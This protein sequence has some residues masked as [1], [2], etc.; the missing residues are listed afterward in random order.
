MQDQAI[1]IRWFPPSWLLIETNNQTIYIDPAW[2][3]KN[4][5]SY[6]NK[7][8]F[9]HY[10]DPMDGLPEPDLPKADIILITHHHQDHVKTA[11]INRLATKE[12]RIYAP[13][14]CSELIART[15]IRVNPGD[16]FEDG[17]AKF[18]AIFS[19][20]TPEGHSTHKV[21]HKG[22]CVGYLLTV[23]EKTLYHAGDTDLIPEMD[24]LG[25][26][27]MAFLPVGGTFTMDHEEALMASRLIKP[28]WFTPIH[29]RKADD[30][31]FQ[32]LVANETATRVHIPKIGEPIFL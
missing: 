4:F 12:T 28:K 30:F 14:R 13:A 32:E 1:Q 2:I 15:F 26:V 24:N 25:N 27:D 19:Y 3:Q 6:P 22:E 21:H 11:T 8:I 23:N 5:R 29:A 18:R 17:E 31:N 20:N 10:P 16:Q 7:I 9:S